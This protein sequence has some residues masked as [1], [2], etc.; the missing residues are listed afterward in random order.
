MPAVDSPGSPGCDFERLGPLLRGRMA[1][2]RAPARMTHWSLAAVLVVAAAGLGAAPSADTVERW[3]P[4]RIASEKFESHAAFDPLTGDL[5]FVRSEADFRGWRILR[6]RCETGGWST[7]MD[8]AFAG[9]GVEADPWFT[10]DGRSLWFISTR[11]TDGH[12][13]TDLDIWRVD[14]DADGR[15][16]RPV[17]LPE[18]INSPGQEWYPR[19]AA[20]GWLYF[21]SNRPGGLGKTDIWRARQDAGG[22]WRIEN[23]GPAVNGPGDE[24]EAQPLPDGRS[25]VVMAG[26]GLYESRLGDTGWSPRRK[27]P[28][29]INLNGSEIGVLASPSGRTLMFSRDLKAG[30]SGEFFVWHREGTEDWPPA[31]PRRP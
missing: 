3:A 10:P 7:P 14:R 1:P 4:E 12:S 8:A 25:L 6:S 29:A 30:D 22:A 19:L 31:C 15:W 9:D 17:R 11:S 2:G 5:Y 27:L 16:G 28:D 13:R 20:D 26:D 18:P 23:A 21:G 24:Y